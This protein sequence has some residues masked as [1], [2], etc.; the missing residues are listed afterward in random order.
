MK[1]LLIVLTVLFFSLTS[2]YSQG[3]THDGNEVREAITTTS[4]HENGEVKEILSFNEEKELN[5]ICYAY[6]KDGVLVGVAS[7]KD[8]VKHGTWKV[9]RNNGTI[10]YKIKYKDG[11]KVGKW[12]VYDEDGNLLAVREFD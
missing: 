10:A 5:G 11:K 2:I 8:G 3:T 1:K 7:Y 9:W 4:Y 6:N 12:K